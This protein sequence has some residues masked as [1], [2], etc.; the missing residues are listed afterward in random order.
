MTRETKIGLL[1]ALAFILV[2]GILL[3]EHVTRATEPPQANLVHAGSTVRAGIGAPGATGAQPPITTITAEQLQPKQ[4]IPTHPELRQPSAPAGVVLVSPTPTAPGQAPTAST[5]VPTPAPA[6][7]APTPT[8]PTLVPS[9]LPDAPPSVQPIVSTDQMTPS[10]W[11]ALER[12]ARAHGE[13]LVPVGDHARPSNVPSPARAELAPP[14]PNGTREYLAEAG[15]N[16]HKIALKTMGASTKANRDAIVRLN[17]SLQQSPDK[18]IVGQRY[19]VP[20]VVGNQT[21]STNVAPSDRASAET[22]RATAQASRATAQTNRAA[23]QTSR[24][25]AQ[26]ARANASSDRADAQP[27]RIASSDVII[28]EVQPGD[29]LWR[30]AVQQIGSPAGIR[31]IREMNPDVLTSD[32]VRVGMKL[33]LPKPPAGQSTA[34]AD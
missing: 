28:Y 19:L 6:S 12:S 27:A 9:P 16:L 20:N 14:A 29:S 18:I 32:A 22:S 26:A 2:V 15:D 10:P 30:I 11:D 25:N 17:P 1:V 13:Q 21:G 7:P 33:R 34:R 5:L 24:T 4:P 23:A 31:I 3:S 8:S